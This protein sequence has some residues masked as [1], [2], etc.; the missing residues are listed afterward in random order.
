M[1]D[2]GYKSGWTTFE[3]HLLGDIFIGA[4]LFALIFAA[5]L[6]FFLPFLMLPLL[7]VALYASIVAHLAWIKGR[8]WLAWS[9]S[10]FIAIPSYAAAVWVF[11]RIWW[12]P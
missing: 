12:S 11:Y 6:A 3:R 4:A 5:S 7:Y 10:L 1:I 8:H 9:S 2:D